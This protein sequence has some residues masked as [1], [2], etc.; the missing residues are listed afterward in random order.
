MKL[1]VLLVMS[2]NSAPLGPQA[3]LVISLRL[4][5]SFLSYMQQSLLGC[6]FLLRL[7]GRCLYI[8]TNTKLVLEVFP[9]I[10]HLHALAVLGAPIASNSLLIATPVMAAICAAV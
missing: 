6:A 4:P 2:C 9:Q 1:I 3:V 8:S 5:W 10:C 7:L